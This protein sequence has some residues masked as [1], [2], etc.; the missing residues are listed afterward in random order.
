MTAMQ[1]KKVAGSTTMQSSSSFMYNPFNRLKDLIDHK[2]LPLSRPAYEAS[3][4]KKESASDHQPEEQLFYEAMAGV[5]PIARDHIAVENLKMKL[6]EKPGYTPDSEALS[7]LVRLVNHG[8][9]FIVSDT[10]EYIEGTGYNVHQEFAKRLHRGDFSIQAHIDLHGLNVENAR[11]AFESFMNASFNSGKRAVLII[12]GRG[13][14]SPREAILK[15]KVREWL[16]HSYWLKRV[17]AYASAKSH[18]GGAGATYVLMRNRP[19]SKKSGKTRPR[20]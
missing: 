11:E 16:G 13:M 4:R 12:H 5:N 6:V 1:K 18:D 19:V 14:S 10:P 8:E 7:R 2:N 17:I 15:N 20:V 3:Q 9:G